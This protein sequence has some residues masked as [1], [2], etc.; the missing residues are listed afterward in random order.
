MSSDDNSSTSRPDRPA[1]PPAGK[2]KRRAHA[3]YKKR[4][5]KK[6]TPVVSAPGGATDV[7]DENKQ[8]ISPDD[9]MPS[10]ADEL[11]IGNVDQCETGV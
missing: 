3:P 6:A 8:N 4:Q 1:E 9:D 10:S 11:D 2:Y 5:R 7:V